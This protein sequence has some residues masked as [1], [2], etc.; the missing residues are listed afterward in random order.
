MH[1]NTNGPKVVIKLTKSET[2][3]L[4]E[5]E[6]IIDRILRNSDVESRDI[7]EWGPEDFAHAFGAEHLN[8]DGTLKES[9]RTQAVN[10]SVPDQAPPVNSDG[11]A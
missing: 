10:D 11:I 2:R 5:A 7:Q 3:K 4:L 1:I 6:Y 8:E 9:P